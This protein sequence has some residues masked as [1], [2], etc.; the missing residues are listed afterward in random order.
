MQGLPFVPRRRGGVK[1][2]ETVCRLLFRFAL[3]NFLKVEERNKEALAV[4]SQALQ[5][6][7]H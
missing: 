4:I 5:Q 3:F 1:V 6:R 7:K 2:A